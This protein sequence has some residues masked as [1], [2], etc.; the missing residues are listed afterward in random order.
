MESPL[1]NFKGLQI[2]AALIQ[3][4]GPLMTYYRE[5]IEKFQ[6]ITNR[7]P[8]MPVIRYGTRR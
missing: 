1:K 3:F 2:I 6:R 8:V 4:M 7:Q 5:A